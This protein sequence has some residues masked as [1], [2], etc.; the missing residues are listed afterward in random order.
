M[1][2][3]VNWYDDMTGS[4]IQDVSDYWEEIRG[5]RPVPLRSSVDPREISSALEFCCILERIAP[6]L[7][8]FRLA[9]MHYN[10][11]MA[12]EVRGLPL[13][14]LFAPQVRDVVR[15]SLEHLFEEPAKV[16]FRLR[17]EGGIG[18]PSLRGQ[19]VLLPLISDLGDISRAIGCLVT[20][21]D[22]GVGSR[23]FLIERREIMP[24]KGAAAPFAVPNTI[25]TES[26][27]G[28]SSLA[29]PA[30]MYQPQLVADLNPC[31]ELPQHR[32]ERP[33][34]RLVRPGI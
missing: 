15:D 1:L 28:L 6:G 17:A 9:G 4:L 8:R 19:L 31:R 13:T 20:E 23:R 10:A 25:R 26:G 12:T 2:R 3:T 24:V 5:I 30:R 18:K 21:G 33:Y 32:S 7:A 34:L 16:H 27:P 14:T 22:I 29:E 11:L